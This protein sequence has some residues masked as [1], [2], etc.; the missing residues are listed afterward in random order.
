MGQIAG[1]MKA[2]EL[3]IAPGAQI[4][5]P[6]STQASLEAAIAAAVAGNGD[7]ILLKRGGIEVS[8][9][10]V[11]AKSGLRVIAVDDGLNPLV[12]GEF[13][14]I[15]SASGFVDGPAAQVTAPTSFHGVGFVSRD[16][17]ATFF[18]GAALLLGGNADGNPFGVW[19]HG[20]RFPKWGL[21]NRIGLAIE[22]SSDCLIEECTFE[23]VGSAFA[24][25]MYIQGAMQNLTIRNNYFRQCTA[26][27][28]CGAFTGSPDGPHLFMHGNFVEDG[29]ML[30]TDGFPGL[31]LIADN[32]SELTT[33]TT[34][35][36]AVATLQGVGWQFSGNHY[37]E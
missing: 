13:N 32:Y 26:A 22:G 24:A 20:C 4:F 5:R 33:G 27:V 14:G 23:G 18:S 2:G 1:S 35:D 21:D 8:S 7:V 34:Y 9:T 30:D 31:G 15:F 19:L 28:K 12:R 3:T 16:T 11:F 36:R 10:V 6:E 37:K 29:L 25:G 17:G